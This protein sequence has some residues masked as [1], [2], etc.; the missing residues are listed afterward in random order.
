MRVDE[1]AR[2]D[3]LGL[4]QLLQSKQVTARELHDCAIQAAERLNPQLNFMASELK[5]ESDFIVDATMSGLPFL[6]KE[7][8]GVKG[9]AIAMG[10][11]LCSGLQL[12]ADGEITHRLRQAGLQFLGETTAPEFGIYPVTES[13]L[14]GV[15]RNPWNLDHSPGGSSGGSS[16]A[17][18]AGV[19][20]V[21]QTSDGGGSIRGPAH[22]VGIFGLKPSA[23]RTPTPKR[24]L[25]DFSSIHVSSRS[26]RDSAAFLDIES[27]AYRGSAYPIQQP[28]RSFLDA[29]QIAPKRL[30]IGVL[31]HSPGST[32]LAVECR[33]AV[34]HAARLAESLGHQVEQAQPAIQWDELI[35]RFMPAWVHALPAAVN[36]VATLSGRKPGPDNVDA[37]TLKFVEY[38]QGVSVDDLL[39]SEAS[40]QAVRHAVDDFFARYDIWLTPSGV[41][42]APEIG[43][44]DPRKLGEAPLDYAMRV[45]HDYALFTPLLNITG[46][47]AASVPLHHGDNGLPAGVQLVG[48]MGAE[49]TLLQL[50]AQFEAHAPW[51]DRHPPHSVFAR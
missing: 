51:I 18:A 39:A 46:H 33:R 44:F 12:P 31:A 37:M 32:P 23:G 30:R 14:H 7:G 26:V 27:A 13:S 42:Q 11:R 41:T 45:L 43:R 40:F 36:R 28:E 4:M 47:P 21:A 49:T 19:V 25:F 10:S 9:G 16:A 17:V 2:Y 50:S 48:A 3:A 6:L 24:G 35:E 34:E 5:R 29:L 22:C 8:T 15:T 20:P 1:Y 38:A